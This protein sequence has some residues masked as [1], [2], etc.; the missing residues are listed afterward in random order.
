[1]SHDFGKISAH[2]CDGHSAA[3]GGLQSPGQ[4]LDASTRTFMEAR[5]GHDFKQ[6]RVHANDQTAE[7]AQAMNAR[8]YTVGHDIAFGAHQYAP[9]APAGQRLLAHELAHVVQQARPSATPPGPAHERDADH[10]AVAIQQNRP[11]AVR[12]ASRPGLARQEAS[13]GAPTPYFNRLN[14][15]YQRAL[16]VAPA[17][18]R[19]QIEQANGALRQ[20]TQA[21][22][23]TPQQIDATIAKAAP[24]LQVAET[25]LE[26]MKAA[27][28]APDPSQATW[29]GEPP[30]AVRQQR[31]RKQQALFAADK[32]ESPFA[33]PPPLQTPTA[34]PGPD[35]SH[36][37]TVDPPPTPFETQLRSGQPFL[38]TMQPPDPEI[39]PRKAV[40]LGPGPPPSKAQLQ[41]MRFEPAGDLPPNT[42]I[43]LPDSDV[44]QT[45][46]LSSRAAMPIRHPKTNQLIGYRL[47]AGV[48]IMEVDRNGKLLSTSGLE[49][50][51]EVDQFD[52]I[53]ALFIVAD[54]GVVIAKL[55][56]PLVKAGVKEAT[57]V[58]G[59]SFNRTANTARAG[60]ARILIGTAE[61]A[62]VLEERAATTLIR[63]EAEG[64]GPTLARAEDAPPAA[65]VQP[66]GVLA[67]VPNAP[68]VARTVESVSQDL[69]TH[70]QGR[71]VAPNN[72]LSD[73]IRRA[74]APLTRVD[75]RAAAAELR[76]IIRM[77][78]RGEVGG[79]RVQS[80]EIVPPTMA[81]R[82]PDL[83]LHLENG[84]ITRLEG[85]SVTSAPAG[86]VTPKPGLG[87]IGRAL[88]D[89][90]EG[91]TGTRSKITQAIVAKAKDT[92]ARASQLTVPMPGVPSGGI[93]SINV[94]VASA[95]VATIDAAVD[96]A[97]ARLG[98]HVERIDIGY[99]G[100]RASPTAA[101]LRPTLTYARQAD[102]SYLR[103]P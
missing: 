69:I 16:E 42:S 30:L 86:L 41:Q 103:V 58:A 26:T 15:I 101:Q 67:P 43:G 44:R 88:A 29:L 13:P 77:L 97:A 49:A 28:P 40:W 53:D 81:Q 59:R 98:P 45:F 10:A 83:V 79:V 78:E 31:A 73:I 8:A 57:A 63:E 32:A 76:D 34:G 56:G 94:T 60:A 72:A 100:P 24:A 84:T 5:F 37:L 2:V 68:A 21:S 102:R 1:M 75:G 54:I 96:A 47:R 19:A 23:V 62:P 82:T 48:T 39:D 14:K 70:Y 92:P 61:A 95:D 22:G 6:V 93:I 11:V 46:R 74:R 90:A 36:Y 50:P 85:R 3:L 89:Y 17:P 52:P 27:S 38:H 4:P 91:I 87:G 20:A 9:G 33:L 18:V 12:A 25:V 71:L 55:A 99:L 64:L 66:F 80:V 51:V 65:L 35:L 7:A